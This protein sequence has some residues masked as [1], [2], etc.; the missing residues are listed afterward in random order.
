MGA[1]R[2]IS[3]YR[4]FSRGDVGLAHALAHQALD[5]GDYRGGHRILGQ[6]LEGRSGEGSSQC[7]WVH[8]QWHMLVFELAVGEWDAA[9]ARF[10]EHIRPHGASDTAATDAPAALWRLKLA[11]SGPVELPWD[12]VRRGALSRM[13]RTRDRYVELHDLLALAGAGDV[14]AL[15]R[16]I[17][18]RA[19]DGEEDRALHGIGRALRFYAAGIYA[20][21]ARAMA[22]VLP[23]LPRIGGSRAQNELFTDLMRRAAEA[24]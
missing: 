22:Q 19:I 7:Q 4:I 6:W 14:D 12:E 9:Y 11:A 5:E 23:S 8:I 20:D 16:W 15:D 2:D 24:A 1:A 13:E 21:A 18:E 17:D 3:G 10:D